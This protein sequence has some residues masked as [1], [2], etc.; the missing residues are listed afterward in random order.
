MK[1]YRAPRVT[2]T[3]ASERCGRPLLFTQGEGWRHEGGGLYWQ[4]C[5]RCRWKGS[6]PYDRLNERTNF[7]CPSCGG[8]LVDD[9]AALP[10]RS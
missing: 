3:C 5:M 7:E 2:A 4:R 10:G 8:R 1:T 9:H 6:K